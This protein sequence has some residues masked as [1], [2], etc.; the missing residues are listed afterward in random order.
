MIAKRKNPEGLEDYESLHV[1]NTRADIIVDILNLSAGLDMA[2]NQINPGEITK[3]A[4][5]A[6]LD[7]LAQSY[8]LFTWRTAH[9][10]LKDE[11][12]VKEEAVTDLD[13]KFDMPDDTHDDLIIYYKFHS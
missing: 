8:L 12:I 7:L 13:Y 10:I 3:K 9:G 11:G 4:R 1:Q 6:V 2:I 5:K